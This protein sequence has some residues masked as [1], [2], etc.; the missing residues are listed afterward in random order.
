MKTKLVPTLDLTEAQTTTLRIFN[1]LGMAT[2]SQVSPLLYDSPANVN[3]HIASLVKLGLLR[4]IGQPKLH[5]SNPLYGLYYGCKRSVH[6]PTILSNYKPIVLQ[7]LRLFAPVGADGDVYFC[8]QRKGEEVFTRVS[9]HRL[10]VSYSAGW[11]AE[12][13]FQLNKRF[14]FESE[15]SLRTIRKWYFGHVPSIS[16]NSR[17]SAV[18]LPDFLLNRNDADL[19]V[20]VELEKKAISYY[21]TYYDHLQE[22]VRVLYLVLRPEMGRDLVEIAKKKARNVLVDYAVIGDNAGLLNALKL[23]LP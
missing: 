18:S 12:A 8:L 7:E 21:H 16:T 15:H 17:G 11:I 20:E 9:R 1:D 19:C 14:W 2:L 22:D 10:L 4:R 6:G 5:T 3:R 13:Y 23:V